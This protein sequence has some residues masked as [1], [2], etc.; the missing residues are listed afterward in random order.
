LEKRNSSSV[1]SASNDAKEKRRVVSGTVGR[2][3]Y[4]KPPNPFFGK[5]SSTQLLSLLPAGIGLEYNTN[6]KRNQL[7][8]GK[9]FEQI[10]ENWMQGSSSKPIFTEFGPRERSPI[11]RQHDLDLETVLRFIFSGAICSSGVHLSLTPIDVVKTKIQTDP[12]LY[13]GVIKS[14][15]TVIED[16]GGMSTLFMGWVPTFLGWFAWGGICFS[17]TE[18]FKRYFTES[19]S[20]ADAITLE[21]PIVIL[22]AA[23]AAFLGSFLSLHL[24][25]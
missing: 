3:G 4:D 24:R 17:C 7:A 16:E 23:L 20:A 25:L 12:V 1:S 22:S 18:A 14:F 15:N 5:S 13:N 8:A 21:V 2:Y 11:E 10:S 6:I 9:G 19:V